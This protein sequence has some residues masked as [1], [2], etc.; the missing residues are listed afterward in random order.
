MLFN[1]TGTHN[2]RDWGTDAYLAAGKLKD[3]SR[4]K[5]ADK[6]FKEAKTKYRPSNTS[7][8]GHSLGGSIASYIG[9]RSDKIITS[10]KGATIGQKTRANETHYRTRGD[11][12]SILNASSKHTK[13]VKN[14]NFIRDPLSSHAVETLKNSKIFV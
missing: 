9:S 4:Y 1:V 5:E 13:A 8:V 3:T 11:L 12:V 6:R 2:L 14:T 7:V 10:N